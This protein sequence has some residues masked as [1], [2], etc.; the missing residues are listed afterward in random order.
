[1]SY[2]CADSNTEVYIETLNTIKSLSYFVVESML[3]GARGALVKILSLSPV[4]CKYERSYSE[5]WVVLLIKQNKDFS[6][7]KSSLRYKLK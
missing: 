3:F 2:L 6:I 1:M 5:R 4:L 7:F